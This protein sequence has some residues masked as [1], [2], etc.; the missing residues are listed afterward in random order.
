MT[1]HQGKLTWFSWF[2]FS[3]QNMETLPELL[4]GAEYCTKATDERE[5]FPNTF[6]GWKVSFKKYLKYV[7]ANLP[8]SWEARIKSSGIWVNLTFFQWTWAFAGI[9]RAKRH[10]DEGFY[11]RIEVDFGFYEVASFG[12]ELVIKYQEVIRPYSN[13]ILSW[14][15]RSMTAVQNSNQWQKWFISA[16]LERSSFIEESSTFACQL[17]VSQNLSSQDTNP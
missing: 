5:I 1:G 11:R 9:C 4:K 16:Q 8:G 15:L 14:A 2:H 13:E 7:T 12:I 6:T 10:K 17:F 3:T